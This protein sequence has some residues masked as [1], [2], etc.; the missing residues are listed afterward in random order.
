MTAYGGLLEPGQ[1]LKAIGEKQ[2]IVPTQWRLARQVWTAFRAPSP[3]RLQALFARDLRP[4]PELRR[5]ILFL[6]QEYPEAHDGLSRL[7]RKPLGEAA[8]LGATRPAWIVGLMLASEKVGDLSLFGLLEGLVS[9]Y[10]LL[11]REPA[12]GEFRA[13]TLTV[14]PRLVGCWR[15]RRGAALSGGG[16]NARN[17]PI[18]RHERRRGLLADAPRIG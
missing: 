8:S 10:P 11:S 4:L 5:T 16:M 13:A 3:A 2:P 17:E 9:A 12:I 6:L 14:T 18:E 15:A 7:Q 1:L